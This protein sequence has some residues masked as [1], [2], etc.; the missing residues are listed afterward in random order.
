MGDGLFLVAIAA[1]LASNSSIFELS[2]F[3]AFELIG[4]LILLPLGGYLADRFN[5]QRVLL[6]TDAMR[7]IV[8]L[9]L[10]LNISSTGS[11]SLAVC[12]FL[13]GASSAAALPAAGSLIS[14]LIPPDADRK[15]LNALRGFLLKTGGVLGPSL[16][17]L[18]LV[19][20]PASWL[21]VI[22]AG[23]FMFSFACI[24]F[25]KE[26]RTVEKTK[27]TGALNTV[28]EFMIDVA[29]GANYVRKVP[30]ML[31]IMAQGAIQVGLV[32]GPET[33][34]LVSY[35]ESSGNLK[36]YGYAMAAAGLGAI[37]GSYAASKIHTSLPGLVSLG[38]ILLM[39]PQLLAMFLNL[40]IWI[41]VSL[42][43][44]KG[45]GYALF[46]VFWITALQEQTPKEVLGRV[47][48]L[49]AFSNMSVQPVGVYL[50]PLALTYLGLANVL[51]YAFLILLITT[52]A[53][54][55]VAGVA[56][57]ADVQPQPPESSSCPEG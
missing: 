15:A 56:R 57:F 2:T 40:N 44:L 53:P 13:M 30:W 6:A 24:L 26:P 33:L 49:D 3:I 9:F 1:Y 21:I 27:S 5:R 23:T 47:L 36:E 8:T 19:S 51:L 22:N 54:L 50:I 46:G 7:A 25:V 10:A 41:I 28:R 17:A 32:L 29:A 12:A 18:A 11:F 39:P 34:I 31:A 20:S 38:A 48:S 43:L 14:E 55:A 35:L 42:G 45:F 37:L 16:A 4:S 52:V